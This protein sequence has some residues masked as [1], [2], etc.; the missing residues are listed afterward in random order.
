MVTKTLNKPA[1][2][3]SQCR[4]KI[5]I[6]YRALELLHESINE[7]ARTVEVAF[8]SEMP[9]QRWFGTEVLDHS[10]ESVRIDRLN[11]S[12]PVLWDHN[13]SDHR[14]VVVKA[15]IDSDRVGR[16][17]LRL[18]R[19]QAADELWRDILDG[20]KSKISVGYAVHR[21]ILEEEDEHGNATYR[22]MDWEPL[23]V[24]FV[25]IPM[26]DGVGLGRGQ[27]SENLETIITRSAPAH[28][29]MTS[30]STTTPTP[31]AP[32]PAAPDFT[33]E[34]DAAAR[35][36]REAAQ[37][38][39]INRV[40]ELTALGAQ[41]NQRDAADKFAAEGKTV[42][43]FKSH[44]L[45]SVGTP[46][47]IGE[48]Q[49]GLN[50]KEVERFSM[51]RAI[52][53]LANPSDARAQDAAGF[54]FEC[55]RAMEQQLGREAAGFFM[56]PDVL[57]QR[58]LTVGSATAG[59]NLVGTDIQGQSFIEVLRNSGRLMPLATVL[60]GLE[61]N[62]AIPRH[63]A[64]TTAYWVAEGGAPTEGAPTFDQVSLTPKTVGAYLD[65]SR[66]LYLQSSIDM[67]SFAMMDLASQLALAID[68]AGL[69]GSGASN[70]P[71]GILN[72]S[73]IGDVAGGT[74]G[75]A[76]TWAD[77]V[78]IKREVAKDNA[79]MGD[80]CWFLNSDTVAK[81]EQTEK[82]SSTAQFIL[83]AD[84]A[85]RRLAGY[86]WIETNQVPNDLDK[87]TSTGVCSAILFGNMRD[88][89]IGMWG[90][91]DINIDRASNSTS[92]GVRIVALQDADIAV[93]HAQS[94][95]AMQDALTA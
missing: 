50:Q 68:L 89:L 92:G 83:D 9:G 94:F 47:P 49:L 76:P 30:K 55:S 35:E 34:R 61:G 86:E 75:A 43:E 24:S 38:A 80:P 8:S 45:E 23:E 42:D 65:I 53:A 3:G 54:E 28:S 57:A 25:S 32:A 20:I 46:A 77:I 91:L 79:V 64:A 71:T 4:E 37:K 82:A 27:D 11:N 39:E 10:P 41:F 81:L 84:R 29:S 66:R 26:D 78:N 85:E 12:G 88:L 51:L 87:G 6:Q 7:E 16:A 22:V 48:Q 5:G 13:R 58:D 18:G 70:Q 44:L 90:A 14:G 93:R 1:A 21:M 2:P 31:P 52:R 17:V 59:G 63:S 74:N 36:G 19:N 72:T 60:T 40:R 62:V 69:A 33:A 56:P 73:G 95:A 67:D 15:S